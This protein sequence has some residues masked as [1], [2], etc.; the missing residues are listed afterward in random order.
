M[1]R[2]RAQRSPRWRCMRK[3]RAVVIVV[4]VWLWKAHVE[5]VVHADPRRMHR[6]RE[7]LQVAQKERI[8]AAFDGHEA[9]GSV[10]A[11]H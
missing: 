8:E 6:A 1:T 9:A 5:H 4:V 2:A 10:D 7:R 11:I 3:S